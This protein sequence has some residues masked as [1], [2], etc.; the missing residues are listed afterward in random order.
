MTVRLFKNSVIV[1][2]SVLPHLVRNSVEKQ[3]TTLNSCKK[4]SYVTCHRVGWPS[5]KATRKQS[6]QRFFGRV[7]N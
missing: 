6:R 1:K 2:N 3:L 7:S 5:M 4:H